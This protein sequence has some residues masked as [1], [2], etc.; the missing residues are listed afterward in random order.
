[1]KIFMP[2]RAESRDFVCSTCGKPFVS[3]SSLNRHVRQKHNPLSEGAETSHRSITVKS[4]LEIYRDY[5]HRN[6]EKLADSR[7]FNKLRWQ[8]HIEILQ[9][10]IKDLIEDRFDGI[11][12]IKPVESSYHEPDSSSTALR[13][14][15]LQDYELYEKNM[16][17]YIRAMQEVSYNLI[18]ER[19]MAKYHNLNPIHSSNNNAVIIDSNSENQTDNSDSGSSQ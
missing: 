14:Q 15:Y 17:V 7:L 11:R 10:R 3:Q 19:T 12:P 6:T 5:Y 18:Y 9:E 2:R 16:E 13:S 8:T 4:R 1:M